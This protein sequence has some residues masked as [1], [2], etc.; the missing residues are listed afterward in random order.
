MKTEFTLPE[1][2]TEALIR[3]T[4]SEA[5]RDCPKSR[6]RIAEE[7]SALVKSP[8]TA[9][10]LDNYTAESRPGYRLPAVWVIP[11]CRVVGNYSLLRAVLGSHISRV[12]S[13][14]ERQI[15][16]HKEATAFLAEL[17]EDEPKSRR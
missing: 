8:V 1:F 17:P 15:E 7:L 12:L 2:A 14:G 11:F 4:L 6:E 13:L 16:A 10:S 3:R 9:R 5:I